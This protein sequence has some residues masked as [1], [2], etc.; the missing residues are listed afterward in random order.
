MK[1]TINFKLLLLLLTVIFLAGTAQAHEHPDKKPGDSAQH[2]AVNEQTAHPGMAGEDAHV[3][4]EAMQEHHE[5]MMEKAALEDFPTLHPLVVHFPIVLLLLA[6][7]SQFAGFFVM[8]EPLSWATLLFVLF[9]FIGAVVATRFVH[10]HTVELSAIPAWLLEQHEKYADLTLYS[11][12]AALVL[13]VLSQFFLKR[14]LWAEALVFVVLAFSAWSI[15][16]ASHFGAQLTHI[17]G[18][19]PQG[20]YLEMHSSAEEHEH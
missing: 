12:L 8:K 6:A 7:L 17:E 16:N 1:K 15:S 9:G 10:P 5:T 20:H 18:I 3:H 2:E 14:V 4:D 13:K 19:G 11:S